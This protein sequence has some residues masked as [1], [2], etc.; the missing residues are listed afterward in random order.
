MLIPGE[1]L[2]LIP[3]PIQF[4]PL[5]LP[6]PM[7]NPNFRPND[8]TWLARV[9]QKFGQLYLRVA[10]GGLS[11][12]K[13]IFADVELD[14]C[15]LGIA[16]NVRHFSIS[17]DCGYRPFCVVCCH[18]CA[19]GEAAGHARRGYRPNVM[20]IVCLVPLCNVPRNGKA[21]SCFVEF[22]TLSKEELS[23]HDAEEMGAAP[24]NEPHVDEPVFGFAHAVAIMA[25]KKE[26]RTVKRRKQDDEEEDD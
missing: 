17:L 9:Q 21:Q 4:P 19:R 13:Q 1:E 24:S 25:Q 15:R 5:D 6:V 16:A 12:R 14:A 3:A 26:E 7:Q 8:E 2:N 22:H 20:C 18:S 10:G 11:V 23:R